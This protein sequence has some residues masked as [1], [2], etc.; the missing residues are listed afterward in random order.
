MFEI[1]A[2]VDG[3]LFGKFAE[4]AKV[5]IHLFDYILQAVLFNK[6]LDLSLLETILFVRSTQCYAWLKNATFWPTLVTGK[7]KTKAYSYSR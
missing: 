3:R 4:T 2:K 1:E 7:S 5:N 6:L